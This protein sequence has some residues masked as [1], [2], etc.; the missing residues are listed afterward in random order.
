MNLILVI[1][2]LM[3]G[4]PIHGQPE[5]QTVPAYARRGQRMTRRAPLVHGDWIAGLDWLVDQ[6]DLRHREIPLTW[7][8]VQ[9]VFPFRAKGGG[10]CAQPPVTITPYRRRDAFRH[11]T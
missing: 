9:R 4:L 1:L 6:P 8:V 3:C 5:M 7:C 2:W 10:G 11:K